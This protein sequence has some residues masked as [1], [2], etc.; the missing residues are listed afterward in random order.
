[1]IHIDISLPFI[2]R[3]LECLC[4]EKLPVDHFIKELIDLVDEGN[5]EEEK[6][7]REEGERKGSFWLCDL[8]RGV[9]L[10]HQLTLRQNGVCSGHRLLFI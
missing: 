1:M 10:N 4:D 3:E 5:S 2:H 8:S 9:R 6:A 7:L